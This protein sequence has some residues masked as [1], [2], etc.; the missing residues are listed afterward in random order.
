MQIAS[1]IF[2]C[3]LSP[4]KCSC[5]DT[6]RV[7][8]M[9]LFTYQCQHCYLYCSSLIVVYTDHKPLVQLFSQLLLNLHQMFW[10]EKPTQFHLDIQCIAGLA[11]IVAD[12]LSQPPVTI[13][14]HLISDPTLHQSLVIWLHIVAVHI[15]LDEVIYVGASILQASRTPQTI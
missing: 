8:F 7:L 11:N 10:V 9:I 2:S 12:E 5:P 14:L 4:T 3:K 13:K 1:Y 15:D 6:N